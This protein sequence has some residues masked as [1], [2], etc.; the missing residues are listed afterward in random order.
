METKSFTEHLDSALWCK[1][2]RIVSDKG[3]AFDTYTVIQKYELLK[4]EAA[5]WLADR[6]TEQHLESQQESG[7]SNDLGYDRFL[8]AFEPETEETVEYP[9]S[10]ALDHALWAK[11][12]EIAREKQ[13]D[14]AQRRSL[15]RY[16]REGLEIGIE[17]YEQGQ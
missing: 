3:H 2:I 5:A 9:A 6:I 4:S 8:R 16:L 7:E 12:G 11:A 15:H 10:D 17:A 14:S 13:L 1:A